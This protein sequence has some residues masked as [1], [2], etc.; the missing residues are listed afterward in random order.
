MGLFKRRPSFDVDYWDVPNNDDCKFDIVGESF[1][2]DQID[3][4]IRDGKRHLWSSEGWTK[5]GVQFWLVRDSHNEH[6]TNAIAVCA[7]TTRGY[8]HTTAVLVGYLDRG[9]AAMH[10]SDV[11][12]PLPVKGTIVGKEGRFGIKLADTEMAA[13]GIS[14]ETLR[15]DLDERVARSLV[16][17]GRERDDEWEVTKPGS[18]D[19]VRLVGLA[20]PPERPPDLRRL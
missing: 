1:R 19:A 15:L 6:D 20:R 18:T 12:H 7:S 2:A 16:R 5:L 8:D 13:H 14:S 11:V 4:L 10:A 9:T 17:R 3:A